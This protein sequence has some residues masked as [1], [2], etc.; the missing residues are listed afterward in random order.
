MGTP[1]KNT[2]HTITSQQAD[3]AKVSKSATSPEPVFEPATPKPAVPQSATSPT[4]TMEERQLHALLE[5]SWLHHNAKLLGRPRRFEET[6]AE[7]AAKLQREA[8][9]AQINL[10]DT[11]AEAK[12]KLLATGY[13]APE[14]WLTV[15]A[16]GELHVEHATATSGTAATSGAATSDTTAATNKPE[17]I[18]LTDSGADI[19]T[20]DAVVKEIYVACMK[21]EAR[22]GQHGGGPQ[23][24]AAKDI[25]DDGPPAANVPAADGS[26]FYKPA[27]FKKWNIGDEVLRK[28]SSDES[29][30]IDGKV[31][32]QKQPNS[33]KGKRAVYWYS[34]PDVRKRWP[35]KF[36]DTKEKL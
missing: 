1:N 10:L 22:I 11:I 33:G 28:N 19:P 16:V 2:P 6:T 36:V 25:T 21:L 26:P 23:D 27:H 3:E 4:N 17:I 5:L 12:N 32:R 18:V 34:E 24:Q 13:D 8:V 7:G 14:S 20:L 35:H 9:H 31:R 15:R 29:E 30:Y